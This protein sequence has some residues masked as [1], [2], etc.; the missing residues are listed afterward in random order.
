M[1]EATD[2]VELIGRSVRL[3]RRGKDYVGL[4]PFHQEKSPSFTVSP[5]KQL[6]HCFGCKKS[7]N[8]FDFV[9]ERDRVEFKDALRT[10]AE[11]ANIPMADAQSGAARK[12]GEI[13]ALRDAQVAACT[14]FEKQLSHATIGKAA[15]EYLHTRGFNDESIKRFHIGL[16]PMGWDGFLTSAEAKKFTPAVLA[17]AGLLKPRQ[18]GEGHY[19][20][21]RNRLMFPIRD[22]EGR[23][24]AF[25]GRVMPGSEDPAKYL[26]S[27]QTPLFDKGR[28]AF[29]LDLARQKIIDTRTV[30]VVEGYTDVVMAHQ[31][32]CTNVVSTLGTAL[33][34]RHLT[35]LGRFADRIVLLFDPDAAGDAA[36]D[37]A[38][39][40]ALS[41]DKLDLAIVSLPD[42]LDPD[43]FFLKHGAEAFEKI[44]REAVD[45][46]TYKWKQLTT[47][48]SL[49]PDDLLGN[50]SAV[51]EF[52]A[53]LSATAQKAG[54]QPKGWD[55][56]LTRASRLTGFS[57]AELQKM[58]GRAAKSQPQRNRRP[59]PGS[60]A[61]A[62]RMP[63]QEIPTAR[64]RAEMFILGYLLSEPSQWADAQKHISP[65][66]FS[67]GPRR[68]LAQTF[69][70]HQQDEGEP[71]LNEF[72]MILEG[73]PEIRDLAVQSAQEI[74][75]LAEPGKMLAAH[76]EYLH[77]ERARMKTDGHQAQLRSG[78][79]QDEVALLE[80][81]SASASVPDPRRLAVPY[82]A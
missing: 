77:G 27:P 5:G 20:T 15:R 55:L 1:L 19:D 72:L 6:Y 24:I 14:F 67:P 39:E 37:R 26:N 4:C 10:L 40:L 32:G 59:G 75:R 82:G 34:E 76:L 3:Q 70:Q 81:I 73:E 71:V 65:E 21:F 38:I 43:E 35:L 45:P 23:V 69:W 25:G 62:R 54:R 49:K 33:T 31:Y 44:V 56:M 52:L 29:G 80:L 11:A 46:V 22:P 17:L 18:Q 12:T 50:Q 60:Q 42:G 2:L 78:V 16:A 48:L 58:A 8:V 79:A 64:D 9:M 53:F 30:A 47:K 63:K 28:C 7:G 51:K 61:D 68:K 57:I 66:D 13:Q 74:S 41:Q 36:V